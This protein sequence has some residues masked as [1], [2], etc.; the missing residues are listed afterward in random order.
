MKKGEMPEISACAMCIPSVV[1]AQRWSSAASVVLNVVTQLNQ[2][3]L[4]AFHGVQTQG[5][6]AVTPRDEWNAIANEHR[7][8][9]DD[10]L[11]DRVLVEKRGDELTAA[12][13]PDVLARLLSKTAHE[14][15][16][17]TVHE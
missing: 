2:P 8:H 9:P 10:E 17:R 4:E 16:D 5:H 3:I 11:V 6:V 12:H 1:Y 15:A 13:Q 7:D 14:R